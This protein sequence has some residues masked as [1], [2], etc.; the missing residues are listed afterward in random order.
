MNIYGDNV[1]DDVCKQVAIKLTDALEA[2]HKEHKLNNGEVMYVTTLMTAC[3]VA[4]SVD[5]FPDPA[6]RVLLAALWMKS[7]NMHTVEAIKN[8]ES[9]RKAQ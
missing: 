5:T 1:R 6:M 9:L 2:Q 7:I 3:M 8:A 4:T